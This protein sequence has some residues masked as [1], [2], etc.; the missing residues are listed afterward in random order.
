M[1]KAKAKPKAKKKA[2]KLKVK[3]FTYDPEPPTREELA[4]EACRHLQGLKP[5]NMGG[6]VVYLLSSSARDSL[7]RL[8]REVAK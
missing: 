1:A 4:E 3:D 6:K 5:S 2:P 8:I 7:Q